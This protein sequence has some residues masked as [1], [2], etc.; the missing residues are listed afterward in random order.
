MARAK[1]RTSGKA[2]TK[3]QQAESAVAETTDDPL[4]PLGP[5]PA[6]AGRWKPI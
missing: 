1:P 6:G 4:K 5:A 2:S 3:S